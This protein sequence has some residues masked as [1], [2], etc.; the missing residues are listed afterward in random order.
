MHNLFKNLNT[1]QPRQWASADQLLSKY[2]EPE[3]STLPS[4]I[5]FMKK[6][7]EKSFRY[8]ISEYH[9]SQARSYGSNEHITDLIISFIPSNGGRERGVKAYEGRKAKILARWPENNS[10]LCSYYDQGQ[11]DGYPLYPLVN[12]VPSDVPLPKL[13]VEQ[14]DKL[15]SNADNSEAENWPE[16][17]QKWCDDDEDEP[18]VDTVVKMDAFAPDAAYPPEY[19]QSIAS[20]SPTASVGASA[21]DKKDENKCHGVGGDSWVIHRDT[22]VKNAEEFLRSGGSI[23]RVSLP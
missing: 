15:R 14:E 10:S 9:N 8:D 6:E 22:A 18:T 12:E 19:L 3:T 16:A 21:E 17:G 5:K 23:S 20:A 1:I 11:I 7:T 13:F 2:F 4:I